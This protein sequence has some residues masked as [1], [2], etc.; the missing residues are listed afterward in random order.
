MNIILNLLVIRTRDIEALSQFYEKLGMNFDY[1]RH[2]N[3]LMHYSA[4]IGETVFE[5]YPFLK[6]QK[7]ADNSLRLGFAVDNLDELIADLKKTDTVIVKD[8][9][10]TEWGY[11]AIVKDLDGRKI[12]LTEH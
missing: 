11:R 8:P 2:G 12:D 4:K 7:V 1:H 3:G 6:N 5:I 9:A 10:L